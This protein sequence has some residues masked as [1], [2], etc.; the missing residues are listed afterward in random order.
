MAQAACRHT[1]AEFTAPAPDNVGLMPFPKTSPL[2]N[3][4]CKRAH[5]WN[6]G[7]KKQIQTRWVTR[8]QGDGTTLKCVGGVSVNV[9]TYREAD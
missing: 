5:S 7:E 6:T 2:C 3:H 8:A 1:K 4:I 9:E